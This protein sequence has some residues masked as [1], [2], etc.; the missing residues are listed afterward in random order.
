MKIANSTGERER[1][2]FKSLK[3]NSTGLATPNLT[4]SMDVQQ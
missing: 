3:S 4:E 1:L 2:C